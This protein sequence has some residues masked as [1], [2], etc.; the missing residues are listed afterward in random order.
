MRPASRTC[1]TRGSVPARARACSSERS[2]S[3]VCE[4]S[5]SPSSWATRMDKAE[6]LVARTSNGCDSMNR[7]HFPTRKLYPVSAKSR[8]IPVT[9]AVTAE[10]IPSNAAAI[11]AATI[12]L[13][14]RRA[15][16]SIRL[17]RS[18]FLRR[19]FRPSQLLPATPMITRPWLRAFS[20]NYN[21]DSRAC[22]GRVEQHLHR[23]RIRH[24]CTK[25]TN[26]I[27]P[28]TSAIDPKLTFWL[29]SEGAQRFEKTAAGGSRC[30][31]L[32]LAATRAFFKAVLDLL[33]IRLGRVLINPPCRT[34]PEMSAFAGSQPRLPTSQRCRTHVRYWH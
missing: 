30:I 5:S 26:S 8:P 3:L 34:S 9:T 10:V 27:G 6:S 25:R 29:P 2:M 23:M 12:L 18:R 32:G 13:E 21:L 4:R 19:G 33:E 31:W 24:G 20:D 11:I 22:R 1:T 14:G 28:A 7:C 16:Q 15:T 17:S